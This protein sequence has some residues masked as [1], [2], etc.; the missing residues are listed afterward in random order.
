M[1]NSH[2]NIFSQPD[3][4]CLKAEDVY[5]GGN[6]SIDERACKL[7][8]DIF[9]SYEPKLDIICPFPPDFGISCKP[10][11]LGVTRRCLHGESEIIED[12]CY[13]P[14][15]YVD[16]EKCLNSNYT[17]V[18]DFYSRNLFFSYSTC[19]GPDYQ[20]DYKSE[21]EKKSRIEDLIIDAIIPGDYFP[22]HFLEETGEISETNTPIKEWR[23]IVYD[24]LQL[25]PR[26][27]PIKGFNFIDRVS[28]GSLAKTNN[29]SFSGAYLDVSL[30]F[31]HIAAGA[32]WITSERLKFIDYTIPIHR[33]PLYFF[34]LK[35]DDQDIG[36]AIM[37]TLRPFDMNL[38]G[39]LT[40]CIVS[41][42]IVNVMSANARGDGSSW[43]QTFT[44]K[45]WR[46]ASR[47]KRTQI[48]AQV[49]LEATLTAF[50]EYFNSGTEMSPESTLIH[51]V[52]A[53]GLGF[54]ILIMTSSYTANLASF[55]T[56]PKVGEYVED[57][58]EA[59]QDDLKICAVETLK[60]TIH[61]HWPE[62]K[63]KNLM[64]WLSSDDYMIVAANMTR[65]RKCD[66]F[67]A[68][69]VDITFLHESKHEQF[70][71][72]GIVSLKKELFSMEWAI[73]IE[74]QYVA[75]FSRSILL[76]RQEGIVFEDS[77]AAYSK[78]LECP[79]YIEPK[80]VDNAQLN[81]LEL[82]LPFI[83]VLICI[84]IGVIFK[85]L[86]RGGIWHS[87]SVALEDESNSN[88]SNNPTEQGQFQEHPHEFKSSEDAEVDVL[89]FKYR[90]ELINYN[91]QRLQKN[92]NGVINRQDL[93]LK[94]I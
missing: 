42:A 89:E 81:I 51:K 74:R 69:A 23:G 57:F 11:D 90:L 77:I 28:G 13:K 19:E 34:E 3:C 38:W 46:S 66:V 55:L 50:T 7:L 9:Q 72:V 33:S 63:K 70:C 91:I 31:G 73:P 39:W 21:I 59:I 49:Y 41:F 6:S 60:E 92:L 40:L 68:D 4:P 15:C 56:V 79:V 10:H 86:I 94:N 78:N 14:W 76:A 18:E 65:D 29:S 62:V 36:F 67:V 53:F 24:Y 47:A 71:D 52:I 8:Q 48:G 87:Y 75:D 58:E 2:T 22:Y 37:K 20:M 12:F 84:A 30:G 32:Y 61:G 5:Q 93:E 82:V 44:N 88:E 17:I 26:K 43:H 1:S 85:V 45:R 64:I 54:F 16:K 27:S 35:K 83:V 25:L 80:G